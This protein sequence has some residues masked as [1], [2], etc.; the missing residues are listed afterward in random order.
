MTGAADEPA[1]AVGLVVFDIDG[2]LADVEH[3]VHH[4][5]GPRKDW[6]AF[7]AAAAADPPLPTGLELARELAADHDLAYLTGRPE[8]LRRVT[9]RWLSTA[10]AAGR[11]AVDATARRLPAGA[12]DEARGTA[13]PV[14]RAEVE[15]EVVIDD[16]E[17]VVDALRDAGYAVLQATWAVQSRTHSRTLRR[18]QEEQ[19]RT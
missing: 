1:A 13:Q 6:R 19:G 17:Q 9:Q 4:L 12:G 16:D 7:F 2:V 5:E 11:P 10:R 3:R 15:V 8:S 14:R 18:A